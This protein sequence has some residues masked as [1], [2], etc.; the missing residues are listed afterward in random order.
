M[1]VW[2]EG[3]FTDIEY[4]S[5]YFKELS[6]L[7]LN[8][9]LALAG[10]DIPCGGEDICPPKD[11]SYLELAF[12]RGGSINIH[13]ATT[14]GKY[15]GT[16]FNPTQVAMARDYAVSDNIT[17]YD[18]SFEE[19]LERFE[20]DK[21]QFDYIVFHGLFSWIS[22]KNRD[23][24]LKIIKKFLKVGGVVY[25][26]YNCMPGWSPKAPSREILS[27]YKV[28]GSAEI[29][30]Q[31]FVKNSLGFMEEFLKVN[32]AYATN[33]PQNRQFVEDLKDK[34]S[35]YISHEY[36]NQ[37]WD[38]FYFYQVAKMME[39]AKCSFASSAECLQ[40]FDK[41]NAMADANKFF[42]K[43]QNKIFK[44]QLRDYYL[45]RQFRKDI[46][47][48]GAKVITHKQGIDRFM[49]TH[50][51]LTNLPK[52]FKDKVQCAIGEIN[53]KQEV[54]EPVL[55]VL[56][57]DSF[58]PKTMREIAQE[59]KLEFGQLLEILML[60]LHQNMISPAQ[61]LTAEGKERAKLYNA[62]VLERLVR[63]EQASYLASPVSATAFMVSSA[64]QIAM[65]AYIKGSKK[66]SEL[67]NF[68]V[69]LFK[70]NKRYMIKDGKV[71]EKD[72]E[73]KEAIKE[74]VKEFLER[75]PLYKAL[76]ILE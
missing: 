64:E 25:N 36:L 72:S 47:I 57:K 52:N 45:N 6:P 11:F 51:V 17:L 54:F 61:P 22:Q 19:L 30:T 24:I 59:C 66:E 56:E 34:D 35:A 1:A 5:G 16:D 9:N 8:L 10:Y 74:V 13:A 75:V 58:R 31:T 49:N 63:Y 29:D 32:P 38:C 62:N 60:A 70:E 4:T 21:P 14:G 68:V 69:K 3:Y 50:F 39:E 73:N 71:L 37:N 26:S 46:Y 33:V 67:V 48:K 55:K 76:G 18:D 43:F 28:I 12:G 2:S 23:I 20:N 42:G 53:I 15:M 40:Q 44:E 27:L 7:L 41:F 65:S